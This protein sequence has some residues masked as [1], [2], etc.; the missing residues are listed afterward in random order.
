MGRP[1]ILFALAFVVCWS[2]VLM[3]CFRPAPEV[4]D[5]SAVAAPEDE[6][7]Q[8]LRQRANEFGDLLLKLRTMTAEEGHYELQF[9][10]VPPLP[11]V[12]L[13][14]SVRLRQEVVP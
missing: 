8:A 7:T 11:N 5:V 14:S 12:L 6:N 1:R 4:K 10:I 3:G 9:F 2:T 13:V